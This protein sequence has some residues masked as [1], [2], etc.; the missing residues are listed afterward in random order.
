MILKYDI[1]VTGEQTVARALAGIERRFV[2]HNARMMRASG[3]R[4]GSLGR[5]G[6]GSE[7][8]ALAREARQVEAYWKSAHK[9]AADYKIRQDQRAATAAERAAQKEAAARIKAAERAAAAA[10]RAQQ[11]ELDANRRAAEALDRQRSRALLQQYNKRVRQEERDAKRRAREAE[12]AAKAAQASRRRFADS[13]FGVVGNSVK[14]TLGA[15]GTFGGAALGLGG[16]FAAAGA[17]QS[18]MSE[19]AAASKLANSGGDPGLKGQ[20]LKEAQQVRGYTGAEVLSA[21]Q[22]FSEKTGDLDAARAVVKDL[23]PLA[24]ATATDFG[25]MGE[26]AGQAFNVI[27]DTVKDPIERLKAVNDVMRTLAA[28]GNLGAVEIK[29]MVTELAGLGAATRKFEGGPAGLIKTMGAM[30][31]ASVARGGS[32]SPAEATSAVSR[33]ADDI[34]KNT[35]DA[36]TKAGIERYADPGKNTKLRAPEEIMLDVLQKTGGDLGK[37]NDLFGIMAARAV[38]G[39]SPLYNEAEAANERLDKKDPRRLKKGEAG[40]AAVR[41]EFA[42]FRD[43]SISDKEIKERADSRLADADLQFKEVLKEFNSRIGSELLPVLAKLIPQFAKLMP[44]VERAATV[45]GK[46]VE[47]FAED[48]F[49]GLAKIV[50]AKLAFDTTVAALGSTAERLKDAMVGAADSVDGASQRMGKAGAMGLGLEL[51]IAAATIIVSS[52][53]INF[54]KSEAEAKSSGEA[55]N[56]VRDFEQKAKAGTAT[57]EDAERARVARDLI[58]ENEASAKKSSFMEEAF[59]WLVGPTDAQ[60]QLNKELTGKETGPIDAADIFNPSKQTWIN[61]Q[62]MMSSEAEQKFTN[63]TNLMEK[64]A[65]DMSEAAKKM[66][67]NPP[68]RTDKPSTV[69]KGG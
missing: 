65:R 8:Q 36:F 39:F 54:E 5:K 12:Q 34:V 45:F 9:R 21:M 1:S 37:V 27:K 46:M 4:S 52:G 20:L 56:I 2:A 24:L 64:A 68:N 33:F 38:G 43:A 32:S 69:K 18:V 11:R 60:R 57:K 47:A 17:I 28:Q 13:A 44:Y 31:Q 23:G 7:T 66:S 67:S 58:R 49:E 3:Q 6:A 30:A 14:G 59:S 25:A 53:I 22:G 41:A 62:S 19:S 48:P 51:G 16:G 35:N 61:T 63:A 40:R 55:L 10:Q 15:V 26:A 29:D 42:A 50:A